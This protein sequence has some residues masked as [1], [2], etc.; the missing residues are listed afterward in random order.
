MRTSLSVKCDAQTTTWPLRN[1][2]RRHRQVARSHQRP[3]GSGVA[4]PL[5]RNRR[6]RRE[7]AGERLLRALASAMGNENLH[8]L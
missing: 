4:T 7:T 2:T 8:D 3:A 6:Q 5:R 1:R